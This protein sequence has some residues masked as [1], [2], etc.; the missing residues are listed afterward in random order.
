MRGV[1]FENM[2]EYASHNFFNAKRALPE[3]FW[4]GKTDM[5]CLKHAVSQSLQFAYAHHIQRLMIT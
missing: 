1:Y 4:N 5:A 2:P 3:W